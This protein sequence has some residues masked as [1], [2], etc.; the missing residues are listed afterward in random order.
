MPAL[1]D[2]PV[3]TTLATARDLADRLTVKVLV[4]GQGPFDFIVD[5]G[6]DHTVLS[7][8]LA[9]R[10]GL[11]PGRQVMV[12]ASSGAQLEPTVLLTTLTVGARQVSGV[13]AAILP[14]AGI[15]AAGML[16]VDSVR[17]QAMIM[18]F[19]TH[20][21]TVRPIAPDLIDPQ[22]IEVGARNRYGQLILLD[23]YV[24]DLPVYVI[25][26]SGAEVTIA[27]ST[28]RR[29]FVDGATASDGHDPA[30]VLSVI[31][32]DTPG[33]YATVPALTL[34]DVTLENLP[35]VFSDLYTFRLFHLENRP[36]MLLGMNALRQ[37]DVVSI[38]YRHRQVRFSLSHSAI[39]LDLA[40]QE[41]QRALNR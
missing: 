26:D 25:L 36:A 21:L 4:N 6:A 11:P 1:A 35:V 9:A 40:D 18:D 32:G 37:F 41:A 34:G 7:T 27:N 24:N 23:A 16:G 14:R 8:E 38:D 3:A 30:Q 28:F 10:L 5:T 29:R 19:R 22:A 20:T 17:D 15:G 2:P 39:R 12:H 31:G 33:Q 13:E